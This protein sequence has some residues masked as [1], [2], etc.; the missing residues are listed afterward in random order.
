MTELENV[1]DSYNSTLAE[2]EDL[3]KEISDS[4]VQETG[5]TLKV[6]PEVPV[7]EPENAY[8]EDDFSTYRTFSCTECSLKTNSQDILILHMKNNRHINRRDFQDIVASNLPKVKIE[9]N[10]RVA[11]SKLPKVNR[12]V[13]PYIK[14]ERKDRIAIS[15]KCRVCE[16][17]FPTTTALRE[18]IKLEHPGTKI[19]YCSKENCDYGTNYRGNLRMH[20]EGFHNQDHSFKCDLCQFRTKWKPTLM[21]HKR[22][23]HG[24]YERKSKYALNPGPKGPIKCDQCE[25]VA[26]SRKFLVVHMRSHRERDANIHCDQCSFVTHTEYGLENHKRRMHSGNA[27]QKIFNCT[28]C[29]FSVSDKLEFKV[30]RRDVHGIKTLQII[31]CKH[32]SEKLRGKEN[33]RKH[34][35]EVHEDALQIIQCWFCD[36]KSTSHF[37]VSKHK[38]TQHPGSDYKC[39]ECTF[40]AKKRNHLNRHIE[41]IHSSKEWLC[42]QCEKV[43]KNQRYL[44]NH[45]MRYHENKKY[46]CDKCNFEAIFQCDLKKHIK[47]CH[48]PEKVKTEPKVKDEVI[49]KCEVEDCTYET[50]AKRYLT[51]HKK[52]VHKEIHESEKPFEC[53]NE[54]CMYKAT[55]ERYLKEHK[56]YCD[57]KTT[58][59]RSLKKQKSVKKVEGDISKCKVSEMKP[60]TDQQDKKLAVFKGCI[61]MYKTKKE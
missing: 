36:Y 5:D 22:E 60:Q 6:E 25:H 48:N 21:E 26:S 30:H 12:R 13:I 18:H 46:K 59:E 29:D 45:K 49:V 53:S 19:F 54:N 17:T 20:V 3:K 41:L 11:T 38:E 56:K 31:Q 44:K 24:V 7:E 58:R 32:C 39:R 50:S 14:Y 61:R 1:I 42:D 4:D 10:R 33:Y 16:S 28:K 8:E 23:K 43:C 52:E 40:V 55:K 9:R 37:E 2:T 34:R 51:R 35:K 47:R 57:S 27:V 15:S